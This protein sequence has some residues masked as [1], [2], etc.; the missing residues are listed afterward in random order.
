[1]SSAA[2]TITAN[3]PADGIDDIGATAKSARYWPWLLLLL[4]TAGVHASAVN[5]AFVAL[6][7]P[8]NVTV[9]PIFTRPGFSWIDL[10]YFWREAYA[11][12]YIPVAYT[13][14][15]GEALFSR[16]LNPPEL[17]TASQ[18]TVALSP[19]LF[20]MGN[21]LLHLANTA[22]VYG[23]L[24]RLVPGT[25]GPLV[26]ALLFGIHPLHVETVAWVTETK[27]LLAAS[28]SLLAY[29]LYLNAAA[30]S[31]AGRRW[32]HAAAAT[33]CFALAVLSKPT[34]VTLPLV[35]AVVEVFVRRRAW[36]PVAVS[37][38]VWLLIGIAFSILT[39]QAQSQGM[40]DVASAGAIDRLRIA[41]DAL[42]FY[43]TK[44]V[45]PVQ[46]VPDYG[47]TPQFVLSAMSSWFSWLIPTAVLL[48][49]LMLRRRAVWLAAVAVFAFS[50]APVLGLVPF[51]F[52]AISTVADRYTY[53]ALLGPSLG[54]AAWL[55]ARRGHFATLSVVCL[56]VACGVQS[57]L[58]SDY[59]QNDRALFERT[60]SVNGRSVLA[61]NALGNLEAEAGNYNRAIE[62][63][64]KALSSDPTSAEAWFN[65]ARAQESQ[66]QLEAAL[67]KYQRSLEYR[68]GYVKAQQAIARVLVKL[69]RLDE[70]V[71]ILDQ[72][73]ATVPT[74]FVARYQL[75]EIHARRGEWAAAEAHYRTVIEQTPEKLE[76]YT[77]LAA[78]LGQQAKWPEAASVLSQAVDITPDDADAWFNLGTARI[79]AGQF[80]RAVEALRRAVELTPNDELA[81][82]QL[83]RALQL[84]GHR[85]EAEIILRGLQALEEP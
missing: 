17:L 50:L 84:S 15:G 27:G 70:A 32:W 14:W 8:V 81:L 37:L 47:R 5:H 42:A 85:A 73:L 82:R 2:S 64:N 6:D 1:M 18:A 54:L 61:A 77:R 65:V 44:L 10:A 23:L 62:F 43:T 29:H 33:V 11:G 66:G 80:D 39:H 36:R 31:Q 58:Q 28:F 20:H 9:N 25:K 21:L 48:V 22:L 19:T 79:E 69:G 24:K 34:A 76:A 45:F 56:L 74:H 13:F 57:R 68:P 4:V 53:F 3:S 55:A 40:L 63:Y 60:L 49:A 35:V 7:D 38:S 72:L 71:V 41:G 16:W 12:L 75:A 59:W 52:Q 83:A 51:G 67:P 46:L 26:G 78:I 30:H